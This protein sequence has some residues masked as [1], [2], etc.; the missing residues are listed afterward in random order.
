MLPLTSCIV[1][2]FIYRSIRHVSSKYPRP[3]PR[4]YRR[5]LFEAALA[6]ILPEGRQIYPTLVEPTNATQKGS[7][8]Y[9]DIELAL[10]DHVR[11]WIQKGEFRVMG[12]C[13]FL[14]VNGRTLWLSKNQ[15]RMQ[16]VELRSYGN[17]I[18]RKIFEGTPLQSLNVLFVGTNCILFGREIESIRT[19]VMATRKLPWVIPLAITCD[20]RIIS[21]DEAKELCTFPSFEDVRAETVGVLQ[22]SLSDTVLSIGRPT[23]DLIN[24]LDCVRSTNENSR[25]DL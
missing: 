25:T 2:N 17:R 19:I 8:E 15:L 5:R 9:K 1:R 7:E 21:M 23:H 3:H 24:I 16:G 12:V 4:P 6:P 14:P 10:V 11:K 18:M 20:S 22:R 13:Q